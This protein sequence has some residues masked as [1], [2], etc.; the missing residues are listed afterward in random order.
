MP[1]FL[2]VCRCQISWITSRTEAAAARHSS[3]SAEFVVSIA[4]TARR[5]VGQRSFPSSM[6]DAVRYRL[7]NSYGRGEPAGPALKHEG[8]L[9]R[10]PLDNAQHAH[11]FAAHWAKEIR[12]AHGHHYAPRGKRGVSITRRRQRRA[13]DGSGTTSAAQPPILCS[14]RSARRSLHCS[15]IHVEKLI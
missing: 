4:P 15:Q 14:L 10:P 7:V 11:P 9:A 13:S 12:V 2:R 6:T 8:L 1:H 3:A 5:P